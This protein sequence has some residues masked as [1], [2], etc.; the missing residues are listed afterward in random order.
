[1]ASFGTSAEELVANGHQSLEGSTSTKVTKNE[2]KTE[3][4]KERQNEEKE[5]RK[6]KK[7]RKKENRKIKRCFS[8]IILTRP[9]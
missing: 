6:G 2:G 4:T 3:R 7:E 8:A 5:E 9:S 1:M